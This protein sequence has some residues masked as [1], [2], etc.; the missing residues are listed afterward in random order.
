MN[1]TIS[2][3]K[4]ILEKINSRITEAEKQLSDLEDRM[5]EFTAA[6][7]NK[8]KR[9][10]TN[11]DSLRDLWDNIKCKNIRIIGNPEREEREKRSK[12]IFKGIIVE[13]FLDMGK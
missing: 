3:M 12:K 5:V 8:E 10:E 13:N 6:E 4:H 11:E 2:E 9:M 7:Q 1:N